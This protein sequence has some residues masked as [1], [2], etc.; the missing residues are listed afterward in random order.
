MKVS[1]EQLSV[2]IDHLQGTCKGLSDACEDLGFKYNDLTME[3]LEEID[4]HLFQCDHCGWWYEISE[5][6]DLET[7]DNMCKD[8]EDEMRDNLEDEDED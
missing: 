5:Q 7:D 8:C 4:N 3:Q 1:K 2:L 6:S